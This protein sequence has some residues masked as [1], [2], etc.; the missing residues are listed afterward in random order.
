LVEGNAPDY[1]D[2]TNFD[3]EEWLSDERNIALRL[4]DDL[5]MAEWIEPGVYAIH[6]W[7]ASRGRVALERAKAMLTELAEHGATQVI[8]EPDAFRR[9]VNLF[10][11]LVGFEHVR[12]AQRPWGKVNVRVL[13]FREHPMPPKYAIGETVSAR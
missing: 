11:R 8:C 7:F 10:C 1:M 5:G 6:V 2:R 13:S 4:S 9:D 3:A 12:Q